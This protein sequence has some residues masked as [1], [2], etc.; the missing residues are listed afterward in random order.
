MQYEAVKKDFKRG[1][2]RALLRLREQPI[3]QDLVGITLLY[4][5]YK[6]VAGL[7]IAFI[8]TRGFRAI[9]MTDT[10]FDKP[11]PIADI[12]F[13]EGLTTQ[14]QLA[15]QSVSLSDIADAL[16]TA[17]PDVTP[18]FLR[19]SFETAPLLLGLMTLFTLCAYALPFVYFILNISNDKPKAAVRLTFQ[20]LVITGGL[21]WIFV[22]IMNGHWIRTPISSAESAGFWIVQGAL[23]LHLFTDPETKARRNVQPLAFIAIFLV[24]I[25]VNFITTGQLFGR[26]TSLYALETEQLQTAISSGWWATIYDDL[27]AFEA[28]ASGLSLGFFII[29]F[30]GGDSLLDFAL[31]RRPLLRTLAGWIILSGLLVVACAFLG[32]TINRPGQVLAWQALFFAAG[33]GCLSD[34]SKKPKQVEQARSIINYFLRRF[35]GKTPPS[36]AGG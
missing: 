30:I 36:K 6:L 15:D 29:V 34:I 19:L 16:N 23:C 24:I 26:D 5:A 2:R 20:G 3:L 22:T 8:E 9:N 28:S 25:T 21:C 35:G 12:P 31:R 18:E 33:T 11:V 17:H 32:V 10:T 13:Y 7:V 14:P 4:L 27:R 1:L